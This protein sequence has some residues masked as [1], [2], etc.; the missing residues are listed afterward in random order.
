M[1]L[2]NLKILAAL[3][4]HSAIEEM[5]FRTNAVANM[6]TTLVGLILA[7]Y[8]LDAMFAEVGSLG[9]WNIYQVLALFGVALTLEGLLEMWL[10][11]SLHALSEKVRT[12]DL[13]CLLLRP[14]DCQFSV[15]FSKVNIWELPRAIIGVAVVVYSMH[16][17][18]TLGGSNLL[19]FA[20]LLMG[21]VAI[22]YSLF[23]ITCTLS[24]WF[25]KIGDIWIVSYT[26]MEVGRFPVSAFPQSVR[27][28]L[29]FFVPIYFISNV[30]VDG[31][32][33]MASQASVVGATLACLIS[34]CISRMFWV[35]ALRSYESASS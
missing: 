11:P 1:T 18:G 14:V 17:Q 24:I 27:V 9:G 29:T 8:F 2:R 5:E 20:G 21:G 32:M 34:L 12:G 22:F 6:I 4:R 28:L 13:D 35:F 7:L 31:A 3:V 33:G 25:V 23:L 16:A 26:I 15:S 19:V 30:P 10:F